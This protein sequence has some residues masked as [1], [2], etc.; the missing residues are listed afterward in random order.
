MISRAITMIELVNPMTY[1]AYRGLAENLVKE[2][3]AAGAEPPEEQLNFTKPNLQHMKRVEKQIE[4]LP[5]LEKLAAAT[6]P[7][8][9]LA[10]AGGY[11]VW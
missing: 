9:A 5:A 8:L 7:N 11:L 3:K 1:S 2:G 10:C 4:L 6:A